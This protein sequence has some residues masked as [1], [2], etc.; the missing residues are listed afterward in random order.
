MKEGRKLLRTL[1]GENMKRYKVSTVLKKAVLC[2]SALVF[3]F[4]VGC[5]GKGPS[6]PNIQDGSWEM[7][8]EMKMEGMPFSVPP[9]KIKQCLSKSDSIPQGKKDK[10][11]DCKIVEK[12]VDGDSITWKSECG[13][14]DEKTTAEGN[15]T[16]SGKAMSGQIRLTT[17]Q[18]VMNQEVSGKYLGPCQN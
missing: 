14:D 9:T 2:L 4:Y 5:K 3:V 15:I 18:G 13:M 16:Y 17:Q 6:G 1:E 11:S 12:K 8:Y 10:G 7:T